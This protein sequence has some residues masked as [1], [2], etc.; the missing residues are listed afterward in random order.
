MKWIGQ[1]IVDLI[2]RFRGDVYLENTTNAPDDPD[3]FLA[4]DSHKKVVYRTGAEVLSD[5]GAGTGTVS[6]DGSTAN[7]VLTYKDED[8]ATVEGNL[9]FNGSRLTLLGD[10]SAT[11]DAFTFQSANADDPLVQIKNTTADNQG[12]RLQF[13]KDRGAAMADNDRIGEMDFVG[14][15]AE[16]N[17]QQYA[18]IMVQ[19]A[20]TDHGSETGKMRFQVAEYDGTQT[21]GLKL[22]GTAAD[23]VIDAT[24]GAGA[25]S[26]TTIAGTLT[27]GTT[28]AMTNA[29]LLSVANQSNI[30]GLGTITSGTW[31]GT[32]IAHAYIG[33][34]AI[35]T[36]NIADAQVTVAKLHADA[37]QTSS[38][39][40]ADNDTSLMT[41]KAIDERIN[42]PAQF[43]HIQHSTFRDDIATTE[44]W[45]PTHSVDEKT[46][47]TNEH[48]PF[49]A[50]YGGK[51]LELHYRTSKNTAAS[52]NAA[53]FKLY[54]IIKTKNVSTSHNTVLDTQVVSTPPANAEDGSA[55]VVK[56]TFDSDAAFDQYDLLSISI[57]H[58][59]DVTD[60]NTKFYITTIWEYDIS[61]ISQ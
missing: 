61:S 52:S 40:Y 12:A 30:T 47:T 2:A 24:I 20:E 37:I 17:I 31:Q 58:S 11:G 33:A 8:E 6:F 55:N 5:I 16:Q 21:D 23:G 51:L 49:L 19:A 41:S 1:H 39:S 38:E 44:H 45:I 4:I 59:V 36:D 7:G 27:M 15:D 35:E 48:I 10:I 25:A 14:E 28:A 34:D 43:I 32:A 9:T 56:V 57:E 46:T 60:S 18:K 13:T 26:T 42:R 54:K 22:E 53:T 29:G 50:P 3:R